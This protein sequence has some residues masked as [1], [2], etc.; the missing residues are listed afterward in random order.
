[1]ADKALR[2][3]R[4]TRIGFKQGGAYGPLRGTS[5]SKG[6]A[7]AF[8]GKEGFKESQKLQ[9]KL[10][11]TTVGKRKLSLDEK[12]RMQA[13]GVITKKT[14]RLIPQH[15]AALKSLSSKQ[16]NQMIKKGYNPKLGKPTRGALTTKQDIKKSLKEGKQEAKYF[17]E[18]KAKGIK[19]SGGV[20]QKQAGGT[21]QPMSH[22]SELTKW[23]KEKWG[24]TKKGKPHST[25]EGRIAAGERAL[26]RNAEYWDKRREE[27]KK[28]KDDP[29]HPREEKRMG[30]GAPSRSR[31]KAGPPAGRPK[32]KK[33]DPGM[34]VKKG[35]VMEKG[36][37]HSTKEGRRAAGRRAGT[38]WHQKFVD[39]HYK[40]PTAMEK[41]KA[42]A[43]EHKE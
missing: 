6:V 39:S 41:G 4:L 8:R 38:R 2:G 18:M 15:E 43:K 33:E 21:V 12:L 26:R 17:K 24:G 20:I 34:Y 35:G 7:K 14:G 11:G 1:M 30:P 40:E 27:E 37:P 23:F 42:K 28:R 32:P 10:L 16:L 5:G 31:P 9:K 29:H 13:K 3:N 25:R 36:K 19:K 22:N